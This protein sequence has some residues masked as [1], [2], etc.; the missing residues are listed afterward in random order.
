MNKP[1]G[2]EESE[3]EIRKRAMDRPF[4]RRK[5]ELL[6]KMDEDTESAAKRQL[7]FL[8]HDKEQREK[9]VSFKRKK[10]TGNASTKGK[11][12]NVLCSSC[13]NRRLSC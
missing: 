12:K 3:E 6:A 2:G 13:S 4:K 9:I 10:P 5:D 11:S 1:S 7:D 8:A